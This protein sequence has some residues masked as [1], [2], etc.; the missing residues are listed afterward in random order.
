VKHAV[1][2]LMRHKHRKHDSHCAHRRSDNRDIRRS[3]P[4]CVAA[5]PPGGRRR[6]AVTRP[7]RALRPQEA[8]GPTT[9]NPPGRDQGRPRQGLLVVRRQQS[10]TPHPRAIARP[11]AQR[12]TRR[13]PTGVRTSRASPSSNN[14]CWTGNGLR[15]RAV[16]TDRTSLRA[17]RR[18]A[19]SSAFLSAQGDGRVRVEQNRVPSRFAE[20]RGEDPGPSVRRTYEQEE[21]RMAKS[22]R[23]GLHIGIEDSH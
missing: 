15:L 22:V 8:T 1:V 4:S 2:G 7:G 14:L 20:Q 11:Q 13:R 9:C 10:T 5:A 17:E 12:T 23:P 18:A 6:R 19:T 3:R 21:M 16:C